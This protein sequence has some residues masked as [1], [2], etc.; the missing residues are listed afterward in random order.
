MNR[1]YALTDKETNQPR[2]IMLSII[3]KQN[4]RGITSMKQLKTINE[5]GYIFLNNFQRRYL[6]N[7][8]SNWVYKH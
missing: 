6:A 7:Q 1:L 4:N 3:W 2:R 8:R 5:I